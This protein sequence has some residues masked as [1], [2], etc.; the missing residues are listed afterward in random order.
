MER[1]GSIST[2]WFPR[3]SMAGIH[4]YGN[5]LVSALP[6]LSSVL[7]PLSFTLLCA[8]VGS[9]T[10]KFHTTLRSKMLPT[11]H[12][13]ICKKNITLDVNQ[14]YNGA[15]ILLRVHGIVPSEQS[16]A[17]WGRSRPILLHQAARLLPSFSPLLLSFDQ[18]SF[19]I[20]CCLVRW[21][22]LGNKYNWATNT[23]AAWKVRWRQPGRELGT[24]G[25]I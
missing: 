12:C 1:M 2:R 4:S 18:R 7:L 10:G 17:A 9:H 8:A 14:D 24:I 25:P 6:S 15:V 11:A 3:L 13:H 19:C 20:F 21:E 22:L 16:S 23:W 5:Q